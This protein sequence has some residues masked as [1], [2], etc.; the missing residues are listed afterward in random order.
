MNDKDP[1]ARLDE[2]KTRLAAIPEYGDA[3]ATIRAKLA[4]RVLTEMGMQIPGWPVVRSIVEKG[5][6][7]YIL[8]G[9]REFTKDHA[10]MLSSLG[11]GEIKGMPDHVLALM[12]SC[13]EEALKAAYSQYQEEVERALARV[14]AAEVQASEAVDA[15]ERH[16]ELSTQLAERSVVAE[17]TIVELRR[18]LEQ[19]R[20][21]RMHMERVLQK[22]RV[23]TKIRST[24]R[25]RVS[26]K[27]EFKK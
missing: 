15:S 27:S 6:S 8:Q 10:E 23:H 24:L 25:R 12:R 20:V 14:A 13:W 3:N 7:N 1:L 21:S 9:I 5:S 16:L 19:E 18:L 11:G 2:I 26:K 4:C 22:G 17:R